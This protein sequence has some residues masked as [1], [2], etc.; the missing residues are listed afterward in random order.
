ML[1]AVCTVLLLGLSGQV[2][3]DSL[4]VVVGAQSWQ[5]RSDLALTDSVNQR[6]RT[7]DNDNLQAWYLK[8]EHPLPLLPNLAFKQQNLHHSSVLTLSTDFLFGAQK[9]LAAQPVTAT[10]TGRWQDFSTYYELADNDLLQ[11]DLGLSIRRLDV[12]LTLQDPNNRV[13]QQIDRWRPMLFADAELAILGT[14]TA[15]FGHVGY[16]KAS[17]DH[18]RDISGGFAWRWLDITPL[19]GYLKIGYQD[20]TL[21]LS[22]LNTTNTV[23]SVRGVFAALE[24]DF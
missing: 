18:S 6:H 22:A 5:G 12:S 24:F 15:I 20:V 13:Q 1:K 21:D 7:T 2:I 17:N 8:F 16:G 19:Q 9:F 10:L 14:D 11:L 4:A 23:P 3:A